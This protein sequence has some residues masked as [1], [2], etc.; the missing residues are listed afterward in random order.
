MVK[1]YDVG[2]LPFPDNYE[3]FIEGARGYPGGN[4]AVEYFVEKIV[5]GLRGKLEAGIDIPNYPQFRDMNEMF[6][7]LIGGIER[8]ENRYY[9]VDRV[10]VK[11]GGILPEVDAI[12]RNAGELYE[13]YGRVKLKV[14]ITGPY[15]LSYSFGF[16]E[17][18]LF[19]KLGEVLA[20]ITSSNLF[21]EK[22][23]EVA[24]L[25]VDE[26][27]F[28]LVDDPL[29]DYGSEGRE[30]ILE[31]WEKIFYEAKS[32]GI[33]TVLHLHSTSDLLYFDVKSLEVIE[34]HVDDPLYTSPSFKKLIEGR[35]KFL[36]ASI[37]RTDFDKL[38]EEI[39]RAEAHRGKS[40]GEE[41]AEVWRRIKRGE[42]DP[43]IYLEDTDIM[44]K[45]LR[46]ILELYGERVLFAG[47]E[48]GLRGF[49]DY[50]TAIT[51]L[52]KTVDAVK[53]L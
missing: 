32:R 34:S 23:V 49:P 16:R 35:D 47:P 33:R 12:R 22:K 30:K 3:K 24:L 26:P 31:A 51:Y 10:E 8:I 52:R 17:P 42:V 53:S 25:S 11:R 38:V 6:L 45:R 19:E 9:V 46:S 7:E 44:R 40:L 50:R 1:T 5:E 36:K 21:R 37:C 43:I 39:I 41:V 13:T 27:V 2:S 20:K 29:R 14:C 48:C 28:A 15:T 4:N 18:I